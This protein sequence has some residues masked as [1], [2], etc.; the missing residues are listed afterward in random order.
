MKE[1]HVRLSVHEDS[2]PSCRLPFRRHSVRGVAD[3]A[4][5]IRTAPGG[6]AG[7]WSR[8]DAR[9]DAGAVRTALRRGGHRDAGVRLPPHRSL[10]RA[11]ATTHLDAA[12]TGRRHR[13]TVLPWR[14][15]RRRPGS[16]RT[17]GDQPWRHERG[18]RG[19]RP[20][21]PRGRRDPMPDRARA[22]RRTQPRHLGPA[23]ADPRHRR[24]R[25][26]RS[27]PPRPPLRA[28][29]RAAGQRCH[30]DRA[31][32][33][34]PGGIPPSRPMVASTTGSPRPTQSPW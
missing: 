18:P 32:S 25:P 15:V 2:D 19:R 23:T 16:A 31:R 22:R 4:H 5:S 3:A 24:G 7:P 21:R 1:G 33:A 9:H 14:A 12:T 27:D 6:G 13:G 34:G 10:R 11:T 20:A 28:D 30:G 29:R 26:A 17:V 8:R